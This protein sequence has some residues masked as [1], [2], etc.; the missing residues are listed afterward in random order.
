MKNAVIVG[1]TS[2]IG[3]ATSQLLYSQEWN[4]ISISR[5][6]E[7]TN[8]ISW[9]V[10]T[11]LPDLSHIP[12]EIHALVYCPGTINL[13]PFK[14]LTPIDFRTDFDVN[15][16]GAVR[17]IQALESR[18]KA[19]NAAV[20]MFSTV[21]VAQGMPF[22]AS[23]AASKGAVEGLC[24]SLAAECAPA[25][26]FNCIAP[27]LTDTP[28]ADKLLNSEVKREA[29]AQRHPLKAI[30]KPEEV[31]AMVALLVSDGGRFITGQ[32]FGIDGGL[33][34]IRG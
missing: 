16:L 1:A 30:G 18:L 8:G 12:D 7:Q 25:I 14:R 19:G 6:A 17:I 24:R 34:T 2:G 9:D 32:T 27:S 33:S 5:S 28:L 29:S 22:H 23:V 20:V 4:I 11:D 31:A 26:R 3:K 15:V 13:K 21:A 10:T